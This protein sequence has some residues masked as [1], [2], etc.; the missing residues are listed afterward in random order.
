MEFFSKDLHSESAEPGFLFAHHCLH[1]VQAN[2]VPLLA[3][4]KTP[5]NKASGFNAA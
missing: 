2:L 1:A 4:V 5:I 3:R